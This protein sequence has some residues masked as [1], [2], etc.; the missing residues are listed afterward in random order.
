MVGHLIPISSDAVNLEQTVESIINHKAGVWDL[1][2]ICNVI[3]TTD[4][5]AIESSHFGDPDRPNRLVW[6]ADKIGR[7]M[8]KSGYR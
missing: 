3:S 2:P 8:V 7:Y 6:R 5:M 1:D 4:K